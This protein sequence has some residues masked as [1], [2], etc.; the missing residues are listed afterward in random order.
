MEN[1]CNINDIIAVYYDGKWNYK[2]VL[3]VEPLPPSDTLIKDFGAISNGDTKENV[4][5]DILGMESN[6]LGQFRIQVLDDI[7]VKF[8]QPRASARFVTKNVVVEIDKYSA[9][10]DPE[11]KLSEFFVF[12]GRYPRVDIRNNS[13]EDLTKTRVVFKGYRYVTEAI[14][15]IDEKL[16]DKYI[17][18]SGRKA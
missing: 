14:E 9:I 11:L 5:L 1:I 12:G 16:V 7:K 3:Y 2:S 4:K 13:G 8:F 17:V 15:E 10:F 6:E 18:A